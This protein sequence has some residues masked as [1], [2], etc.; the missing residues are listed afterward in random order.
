[1]AELAADGRQVALCACDERAENPV[2]DRPEVHFV[3]GDLTRDDVMSR[4]AVHR[5]GTAVI[6]GR[7]DNETLAIAVALDHANPSV[8]LVAAGRD[9][10]RRDSLR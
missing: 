8:H 5:A 3:R 7:D 6:D 9:L 1:M 4:A 10:S 2:P